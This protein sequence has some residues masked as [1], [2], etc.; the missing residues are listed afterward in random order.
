MM[1]GLLQGFQRSLHMWLVV[2]VIAGDSGNRHAQEAQ[3]NG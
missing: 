3:N 1:L 2:I